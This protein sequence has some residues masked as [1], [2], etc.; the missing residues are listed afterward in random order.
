MLLTNNI[1]NF[2]DILLTSIFFADC[3]AMQL[4]DG[5]PNNVQCNIL[6]TCFGI[7]CCLDLDIGNLQHTYAMEL[8]VDPCLGKFTIKFDNWR[9]EKSVTLADV[10]IS[11]E[12]TIGNAVN[13]R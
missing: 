5:L 11:Q 12:I 4:A 6:N 3:P 2:K 9:Y 1:D 10:D 7:E 8:N 13:I